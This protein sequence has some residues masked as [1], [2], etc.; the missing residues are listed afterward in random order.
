[1]TCWAVDHLWT[2]KSSSRFLL[3]VNKFRQRRL[4]HPA[5]CEGEQAACAHTTRAPL[6]QLQ[7]HSS[8]S[9]CD[10]LLALS[11]TCEPLASNHAWTAQHI[12]SCQVKQA[13]NSFRISAGLPQPRWLLL[14]LQ[15]DSALVGLAASDQ[16]QT[17]RI[18]NLP[19]SVK[20][21]VKMSCQQGV[22][23]TTLCDRIDSKLSW[24]NFLLCLSFLLLISCVLLLYSYR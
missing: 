8:W 7:E 9:S 14:Q 20:K 22:V 19:W 10:K 16:T 12:C 15:L 11:T 13:R 1:M 4:I 21:C 24:K 2:C 5:A 17:Q 3:S 23:P 18:S 6:L